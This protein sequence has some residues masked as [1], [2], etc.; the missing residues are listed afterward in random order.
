[1]TVTEKHR[2]EYKL[3]DQAINE[4]SQVMNRIETL[5]AAAEEH[6]RDAAEL[7]RRA[8]MGRRAFEQLPQ[9]VYV[10][11][12]NL[13]YVLCNETYARDL[14]IRPEEISGKNVDDFF[15]GEVAEKVYAEEKEILCFGV[16]RE[17]EETYF[18]SGEELTVFATRT[19]VRD[20]N[21]DVIGLQV[22]LQDITDDRRR[23]EQH[24]SQLEHLEEQ[25]VQEKTKSDALSTDLERMTAQRDLLQAEIKDMRASM[26]KQLALRD[27]EREKLREDLQRETAGRQEAVERLQQSFT[28][29]QDL[30]NSV[31]GGNGSARERGSAPCETYQS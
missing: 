16:S 31:L 25:L 12:V 19:P 14:Q 6:R 30:M 22:V 24:S 23:K 21:G 27:V 11:D 3:I 29:I 17:T 20:D 1:M 4:L 26:K 18:V 8:M 2:T 7:R 28:Q 10:K 9:R 13:D 15:P 5:E